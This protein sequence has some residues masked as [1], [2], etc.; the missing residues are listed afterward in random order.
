MNVSPKL[1]IST[2]GKMISAARLAAFYNPRFTISYATI[3]YR[4]VSLCAVEYV[5]RNRKI[6]R[7]H[8]LI[9]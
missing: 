6:V 7:T 9:L 3:K 5:F 2:I 1:Y 4:A 8:F